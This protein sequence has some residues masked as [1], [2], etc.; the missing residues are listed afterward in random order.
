[1]F[2][3]L[4]V[5]IV[6]GS[7][8]NNMLFLCRRFFFWGGASLSL[9]QQVDIVGGNLKLIIWFSDVRV[10]LVSLIILYL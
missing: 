2:L 9:R 3:R 10:Q 8:I 1:M 5:N 6:G 7:E 4:Q